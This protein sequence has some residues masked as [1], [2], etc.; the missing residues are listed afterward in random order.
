MG[1][2]ELYQETLGDKDFEMDRFLKLLKEIK[3]G[4]DKVFKRINVAEDTIEVLKDDVK[5]IKGDVEKMCKAFPEGD[6]EGHRR[7]HQLIQERTDEVR[8]LRQAIIEKTVSGLIWASVIAAALFF[9]KGF[10]SHLAEIFKG[11]S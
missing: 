8:R 1:I 4:Q 9:W 10:L 3:D 6:V 11:G 2:K 5:D 7:Y